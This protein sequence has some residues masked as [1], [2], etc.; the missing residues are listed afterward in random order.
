MA[1][2]MGNMLFALVVKILHIPGLRKT[3]E[4]IVPKNAWI[5]RQ[6]GGM[7]PQGDQG[8]D[9]V[10]HRNYVGGQGD[11]WDIIGSLQFEFLKL[12]GLKYEDVLLDIGCGALRGGVYFIPYLKVGHYLGLDKEQ[13]LIDLGIKEELGQELLE[14]KKPEFVVS[15]G[16]EISK[17]S[18]KPTYAMAQSVFTHLTEEDIALCL[19]TLRDKVDPGARFFATF[20]EVE[21]PMWNPNDSHS[22]KRFLYTHE[23]LVALGKANNWDTN[24]IGDWGHPRN[25]MMM[26]FIAV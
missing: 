8:I 24:Y 16:F 11:Y 4:K 13:K 19:K 20:H 23:Q 7:T 17:F 18:N 26:E 14:A 22:H 6:F 9:L 12:R 21:K 3:I 2:L 1:H 25:H 5:A 10:G 15:T